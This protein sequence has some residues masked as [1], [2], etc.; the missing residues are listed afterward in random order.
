MQLCS[1]INIRHRRK[2]PHKLQKIDTSSQNQLLNNPSAVR[3]RMIAYFRLCGRLKE[4]KQ[5]VEFYHQSRKNRHKFTPLL[6]AFAL[7]GASHD[8][9]VFPAFSR[10]I[11]ADMAADGQQAD[12]RTIR[13]LL[14]IASNHGEIDSALQYFKFCDQKCVLL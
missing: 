11:K 8:P 7:Y 5:A 3:E 4:S 13:A 14:G 1:A 10:V 2:R 6:Y 12:E 9:N